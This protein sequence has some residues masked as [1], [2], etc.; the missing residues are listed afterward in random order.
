MTTDDAF[1]E[2]LGSVWEKVTANREC[3]EF[4]VTEELIR[5]SLPRRFRRKK[6]RAIGGR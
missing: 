6:W 3:G 5:D 1:I 4:F 2:W